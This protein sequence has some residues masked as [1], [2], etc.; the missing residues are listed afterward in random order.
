VRV[1]VYDYSAPL[2]SNTYLIW[3]R[4]FRSRDVQFRD[5]SVGPDPL[6]GE[7]GIEK[8]KWKGLGGRMK[9]EGKGEQR[10]PRDVPNI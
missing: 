3:R 7:R 8:R 10:R 5:F 4:V 2:C 9:G 1:S 6:F